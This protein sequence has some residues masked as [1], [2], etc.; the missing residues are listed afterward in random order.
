[1]AEKL[2][3]EKPYLSSCEA[4]ITSINNGEVTLDRTVFFAFSG[5]QQSDSGTIGGF[6]VEDARAQGKEIYYKLGGNPHF[7]VGDKVQV[8]IDMEKR[9][10]IMRLHSAAH[11]AFFLF[12]N[13]T[14]IDKLIGS[15]VT[16][17][18]SRVDFEHDGSIS[19][20]LIT[21]QQEMDELIRRNVP[22]Q[23][24]PDEKNQDKWWWECES[25]RAPCGGTHVKSTGELGKIILKRKNIGF[26]KERIEI[27]IA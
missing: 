12:A 3:R 6:K 5:G 10:R 20:K 2:F 11:I 9:L 4:S 22:I 25:M 17:E 21:T 19:E 13:H 16:E 24:Y 15:N 14:K 18:K 26:G 1:M 7:S 8:K 23:A 27:T